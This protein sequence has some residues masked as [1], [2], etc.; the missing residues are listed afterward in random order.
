MKIILGFMKCGCL[1]LKLA[2]WTL[3]SKTKVL[4]DLEN[5]LMTFTLVIP[6]QFY[7]FQ[8]RTH[9]TSTRAKVAQTF[10]SG[11]IIVLRKSLMKRLES[12]WLL[13]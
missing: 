9:T 11:R 6:V 12:S 2:P 13:T 8:T 7:N 10:G 4:E 1:N 5:N 3:H